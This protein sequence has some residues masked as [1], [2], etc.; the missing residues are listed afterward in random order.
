LHE[1]EAR[2]VG[3]L[4]R[5]EPD[6]DA[7]LHVAEQAVGD[8]GAAEEQPDADDEPARALVAM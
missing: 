2:A 5:V 1:L 7:P 8:V 6:G 3:V 4:E